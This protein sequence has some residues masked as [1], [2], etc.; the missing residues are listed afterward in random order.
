MFPKRDRL[1]TVTVKQAVSH[2]VA[3]GDRRTVIVMR[4]VSGSGKTTMSRI[5]TSTL[6]QAGLKVGI[7]S[8]D[9]FFMVEGRYKFD[10]MKLAAFHKQNLKNFIKD[11]QNDIDVVICNN[12]NLLPWQSEP[13]TN[14]A[15]EYGY[16]I[17]F[18]NFLTRG[19]K[20]HLNAQPVS[21]EKPDAHNLSEEL[22]IR[23]I[24]DFNTYNE[25]LDKSCA[26]NHEK[27]FTYVWN[28]DKCERERTNLPIKHFDSDY[29]ISI[30]SNQYHQI[31]QIIGQTMLNLIRE[32]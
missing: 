20:A 14:A 5:I 29:V 15:R 10:I 1:T 31:K 19:L 4:A 16:Q 24:D 28:N 32:G 21:L 3:D 8:T 11:L 27:H 30:E 17:I 25:L 6:E 26:I 12:M 7:H 23:L 13:Y 18:L 9:D 2:K 22:L